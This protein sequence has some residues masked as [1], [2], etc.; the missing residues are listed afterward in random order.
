MRKPIL[1]ILLL[2]VS[3]NNIFAAHFLG[4]DV[5]IVNIKDQNGL[6]TNY[7]KIRV[8]IYNGNI[9]MTPGGSMIGYVYNKVLNNLD[10]T[11]SLTKIGTTNLITYPKADCYLEAAILRVLSSVYESRVFSLFSFSKPK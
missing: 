1:L 8:K 4:H 10:S 11:L 6:A 7:Y 2:L 9:G 3:I 5:S